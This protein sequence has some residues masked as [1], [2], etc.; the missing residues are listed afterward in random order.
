MKKE[1]RELRSVPTVLILTLPLLGAVHSLLVVFDVLEMGSWPNFIVLSLVPI[2]WAF[3]IAKETNKPFTPLLVIGGIYGVL[4][5]VIQFIHWFLNRESLGIGDSNWS[6]DDLLN[7][8]NQ[9]LIPAFRFIGNIGFGV[10]VGAFAGLIA[11][12]IVNSRKNN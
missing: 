10:L 9:L 8:I 7:A 3:V 1:D 12:I 5:A 2:L 11:R 4:T 6:L